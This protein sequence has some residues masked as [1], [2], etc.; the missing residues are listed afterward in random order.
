MPTVAISESDTVENVGWPL[1]SLASSFRSQV[2]SLRV[3][4]PTCEFECRPMSGP[5]GNVIP[6][7]SMVENVKA[8]V[9][10]S[11][12]VVYASLAIL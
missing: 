7:S 3:S 5:V 8:A 2:I 12:V 9:E 10:L 6:R 11:L 4:W 1:K